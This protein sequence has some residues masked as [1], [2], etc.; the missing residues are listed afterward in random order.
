MHAVK[1][2]AK[3]HSLQMIFVWSTWVS[4]QPQEFC[5]AQLHDISKRKQNNIEIYQPYAVLFLDFVHLSWLT[6]NKFFWSFPNFFHLC[7]SFFLFLYDPLSILL[8]VFRKVTSGCQQ[9][10]TLVSPVIINISKIS[11]S[12]GFYI[13]MGSLPNT[14]SVI[15]QR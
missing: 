14:S 5:L 6:E 7:Y 9:S 13:F 4:L 3:K 2:L 10:I 8:Q 12:E 15:P 1:H 11:V